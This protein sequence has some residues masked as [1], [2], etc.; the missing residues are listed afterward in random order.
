MS[1]T[2]NLVV[3]GELTIKQVYNALNRLNIKPIL[4]EEEI[5]NDLLDSSNRSVIVPIE[6]GGVTRRLFLW[7]MPNS[8]FKREVQPDIV[9]GPRKFKNSKK[10]FLNISLDASELATKIL[11]QLGRELDGGYVQIND[12]ATGRGGQY[13]LVEK[14]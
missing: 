2:A 13:I 11:I 8:T 5:T 12:C 1:E 6:V 14:K 3:K 4:S 10:D 7:Y 9:I